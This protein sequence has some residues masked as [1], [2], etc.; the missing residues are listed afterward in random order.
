MGSNPEYQDTPMDIAQ[1][2]NL[3]EKASESSETS[4][5]ESDSQG[6]LWY[7]IIIIIINFIFYSA[8]KVH[9]K[10]LY[11]EEQNWEK[12]IKTIK[13]KINIFHMTR[14]ITTSYSEKYVLRTDLK[15]LKIQP[16]WSQKEESS[17]VL[18][19]KTKGPIP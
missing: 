4:D 13:S 11:T 10:V 6:E 9:L 7:S 5:S 19:H 3:P 8:F 17:R 14:K 16:V 18:V 12:T 1:L 15:T 2:P